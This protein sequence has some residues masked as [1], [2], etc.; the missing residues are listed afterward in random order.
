MP[1]AGIGIKQVAIKQMAGDFIIKTQAVVACHA[2]AG[3]AH[4]ALHLT[5]ELGFG[6][7][8]TLRFLRRDAGNQASGGVRQIIIGGL[9]VQLDRVADFIE[10]GIGA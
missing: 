8:T 6:K 5:G 1:L 2:G 4:G 3:L 7:P 10:V 9:T